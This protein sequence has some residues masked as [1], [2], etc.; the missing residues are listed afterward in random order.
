LS[1]STTTAELGTGIVLPVR[2]TNGE[3]SDDDAIRRRV[4]A[5]PGWYV[6]DLRAGGVVEECVTGVEFS[7]PSVQ[8]DVLPEVRWWYWRLTSRY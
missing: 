4:D 3:L 7:S 8:L 5:L 1:S 6:A 2:E